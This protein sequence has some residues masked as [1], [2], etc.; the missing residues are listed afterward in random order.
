MHRS[1]LI[2]LLNLLLGTFVAADLMRALR[3]GRARGRGGFVTR[4]K[5]PEKYWR[6]VYASCVVLVFCAV[7][8]LSAIIWPES[9]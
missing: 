4:Q 9:F 6:Y 7:V 2:I 3:T 1:Q 5:R 8:L